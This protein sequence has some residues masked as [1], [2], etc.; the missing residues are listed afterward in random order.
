MKDVSTLK[1][2]MVMHL[3]SLYDAENQWSEQ[4]KESASSI[5]SSD[6]KKIFATGSMS[7]A[8]HAETIKKNS[9]RFAKRKP[10]KEKYDRSGPCKRDQGIKGH[11]CRS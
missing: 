11:G 6:L 1:D 7:A 10:G 9:Y 4:L 8:G 3:Q 5:N 2:L